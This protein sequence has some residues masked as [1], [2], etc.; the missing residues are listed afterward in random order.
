MGSRGQDDYFA[1]FDFSAKQDP[2]P[3]MLVQNH[4]DKVREFLGQC[5]SFRKELIKPHVLVLGETEE[6]KNLKTEKRVKYIHGNLGSGTFTFLGGH[7]PEDYAHIVGE[8]D[9]DLAYYPNSPGYRLI[10][11]NILFPAVM[12]EEKKT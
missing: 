1:L 3:T 6:Q 7:D 4:V 9:T 11:N 8:K 10:L 12:M 5:T 2:V